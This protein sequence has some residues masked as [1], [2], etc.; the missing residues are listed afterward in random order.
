MK[1]ILLLLAVIALW[2]I[3]RRLLARGLAG[4][5]ARAVG[6]AAL[7][8][9]PDRIR[10]VQASPDAFKDTAA[11]RR[12][13]SPLLAA[14]FTD[15]GSYHVNEMP[16]V[17]VELLAKP[18]E[19]FY[20]A[21][22]EHPQAGHW[23]DLVTRYADGTS[24]TFTTVKPTGLE[25]RPGHAHVH[26]PE[27]D[28]AGLYRRARGERERGPVKPAMVASAVADFETAYAEEMAWRKQQGVS[29]GEVA[30]VARRRAA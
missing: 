2:P 3:A 25:A 1:I 14:G 28:P 21:I 8:Q 17:L 20:A 4:V 16:G 12:L 13:A 22:Y 27:L 10:L 29:A 11:V 6:Q 7:A 5:F 15:A 30:A 19:G 26:A 9:Q 18:D 24:A 23:I